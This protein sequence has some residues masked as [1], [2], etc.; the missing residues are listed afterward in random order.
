MLVSQLN[1][2][3]R[4]KTKS[5][6]AVKTTFFREGVAKTIHFKLTR[7]AKTVSKLV[8]T[9][10]NQAKSCKSKITGEVTTY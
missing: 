8:G 6:V 3:T 2:K 9:L 5:S 7:L 10:Q 4:F 1:D